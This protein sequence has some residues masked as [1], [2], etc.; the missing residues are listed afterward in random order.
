MKPGVKPS[1][2]EEKKE[3]K[4][5]DSAW[6]ILH[7]GL[8]C[9][10]GFSTVKAEAVHDCHHRLKSDITSAVREP[11]SRLL[12]TNHTTSLQRMVMKIVALIQPQ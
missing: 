7:L 9:L 8:Q 11:I 10:L 6:S 1:M 12:Q 4:K 3:Q 2:T 5:K